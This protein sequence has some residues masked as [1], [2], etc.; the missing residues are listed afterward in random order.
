MDIKN[1]DKIVDKWHPIIENLDYVGTKL[2]E[3]C[4]YAENHSIIDSKEM[5]CN[6]YLPVSIK[7][8][9]SIESL[10]MENLSFNLTDKKTT[11]HVTEID[12][13]KEY[14]VKDKFE[15]GNLREQMR[16]TTDMVQEVERNLIKIASSKI[17]DNIKSLN[18]GNCEIIFE[19]G[20]I[21]KTID[22]VVKE[23]HPVMRLVYNYNLK[24]K[25]N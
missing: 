1:E 17:N 18:T 9:L 25:Q 23:G 10:N 13:F 6:F 4:Y 11:E 14:N 5:D 12:L 7:L 24:S 21:I 8:L 20:K 19:T 2:K 22:M 3:M 16:S 15:L